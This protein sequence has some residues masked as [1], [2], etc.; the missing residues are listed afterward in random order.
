MM[1]RAILQRSEGDDQGTP[2]RLI[3]PV[4]SGLTMELP[5]R[6]NR[7][8]ESCIPAGV[9]DV[10]WTLSPRLKRWTYE[11][12]NVPGRG[13]IRLHSGN[14]AGDKI[15]GYLSHSLGCPLVGAYLGA[16][17]GQRAVLLSKPTVAKFER[18]LDHQPFTLEI[19]NA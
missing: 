14:L 2:G 1:L 9:Y 11:I 6:L 4:F 3:C 19:R 13:G 8:D 17:K 7:Q 5:D 10:R 12:M 18:A 16:I 15:K